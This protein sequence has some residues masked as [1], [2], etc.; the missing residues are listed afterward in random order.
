MLTSLSPAGSIMVS[1]TDRVLSSDNSLTRFYSFENSE[2][3]NR[4]AK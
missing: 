2:R 1:Q 3:K 4:V